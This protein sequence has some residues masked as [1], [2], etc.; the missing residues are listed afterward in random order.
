MIM[1]EM[2]LPNRAILT[3]PLGLEEGNS[4]Y[5]CYHAGYAK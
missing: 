3:V 1:L 4:N 5:K 2:S